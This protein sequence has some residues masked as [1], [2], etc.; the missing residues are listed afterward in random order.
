MGGP[1]EWLP[2]EEARLVAAMLKLDGRPEMSWSRV[3]SLVK[4]RNGPQC[5]T[6]WQ[7]SRPA[8]RERG[9]EAWSK[10]RWD[11][12]D[13][14]RLLQQLFDE[15]ADDEE[16]VDWTKLCCGWLNARSPHFLRMKWSCLRRSVPG[17]DLKAF[18]G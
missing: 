16:E 2:D 10:R 14:L 1:G 15:K 6:K 5:F 7:Y 9:E 3:A 12:R 17:Y 8:L 11:K 4:T 18:E 13:N